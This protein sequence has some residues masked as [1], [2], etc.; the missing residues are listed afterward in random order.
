MKA[1]SFTDIHNNFFIT[2]IEN[3]SYLSKE[4]VDNKDIHEFR[5]FVHIIGGRCIEVGIYTFNVIL[6]YYNKEKK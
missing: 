3:I 2:K 4:Y 1:I 5:Y 6:I